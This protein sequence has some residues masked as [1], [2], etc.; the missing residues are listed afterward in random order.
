MASFKEKGVPAPKEF[1]TGTVWVKMNLTAEDGYNTMIGTVTFEPN[2]RT[3]WHSHTSG[4]ILLVTQGIGRYQ[5]KGKPIQIIREGDV[6][7][8]PKN[9]VHWHGASCHNLMTHI[10]IVPDLDKDKT[11][12]LQPVTDEEYNNNQSSEQ[13]QAKEIKLTEVAVKNHEA[14]WPNYQ[15]KAKHTDP[16][17]IEVFDNFAFDEVFSHGTID[18]KTR[19]MAIMASTIASQ[20]LSEYKMFVNA[21]LNIGVT[22]IEVKEILYQSVPY[23]G[24][25][26]VIDFIYTTNEIF[27][28]HGI[29]LPVESQSTTNS[30]TRLEKGLALQKVIFGEM[31]D[32]MYEQ[33]PKDQIHF[34]QYLSANCFGDYLTR[35]GLDIKTREL[36]TYSMLIS[37]GGAESQ[38]KGHIQG[39][40]NVGNDKATINGITTQLLPYIGYPRTLNA[41]KCLNDVIPDEI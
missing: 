21:G 32:K 13:K 31:I 10:A 38:V 28:E 1:F 40:V 34:Q 33:S 9:A 15:S 24:I 6:V 5:E 30:E 37:M 26:K 19:V 17:L 8:I 7:K 22:P 12:W 2:G 27:A 25:A 16:E 11:A 3:N 35:T 14:L 36:L 41:L 23:V 39:N 29:E 4:Q 20:A 18:P